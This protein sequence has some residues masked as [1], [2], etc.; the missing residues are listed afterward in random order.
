LPLWART[1]PGAIPDAILG[2]VR[3]EIEFLDSVI[4][5][6][7]GP[8]IVRYVGG[9]NDGQSEVV[10]GREPPAARIIGAEHGL[11]RRSVRCV[12]DGIL[13]YVWVAE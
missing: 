13:R 5:E 10:Y 6:Q 9:P 1:Q 8:T 11:Y 4:K 3:G 2:R 12:D 7:H